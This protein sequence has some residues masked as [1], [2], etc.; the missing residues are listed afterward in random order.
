M[1]RKNAG[2][3]MRAQ[4]CGR[5][6]AGCMRHTPATLRQKIRFNSRRNLCYSFLLSAAVEAIAYHSFPFSTG[7]RS[8]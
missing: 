5:K 1:W 7:L 8:L 6:N 2:A 4:K 3:K